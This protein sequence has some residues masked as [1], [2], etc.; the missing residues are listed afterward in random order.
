MKIYIPWSQSAGKY[1]FGKESLG[2]YEDQI[3]RYKDVIYYNN[4]WTST[5]S[6]V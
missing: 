3:N 2:G 1:Q 6:S 5:F 4:K